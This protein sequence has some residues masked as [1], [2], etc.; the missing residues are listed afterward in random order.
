M[1]KSPFKSPFGNN[2]GTTISNGIFGNSITPTG[3]SLFG[4]IGNPKPT[5]LFGNATTL[6]PSTNNTSLF[7]ILF[8]INIKFKSK[9]LI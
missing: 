6:F 5:G 3:N 1:K 7:G 9:I 2:N 8:K 4:N